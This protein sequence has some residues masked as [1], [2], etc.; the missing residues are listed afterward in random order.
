[1]E[2]DRRKNLFVRLE[3]ASFTEDVRERTHDELLVPSNA[4]VK[5]QME[6]N[7]LSKFKKEGLRGAAQQSE[8]RAKE[9]S[10][11]LVTA[12]GGPSAKRDALMKKHA[13]SSAGSPF[14]S[15]TPEFTTGHGGQLSYMKENLKS[16]SPQVVNIY[17]TERAQ[18]NTFNK[19]EH[20]LLLPV[21][22]RRSERVGALHVLP[23]KKDGMVK[24]VRPMFVDLSG[25]KPKLY[26]G[27]R[28]VERFKDMSRK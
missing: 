21:G 28:A 6:S 11:K 2:D 5:R 18:P 17:E 24:M 22:A 3:K 25:E 1:M 10:D 12:E 15:G 27:A 23:V 19:R 13:T 8:R 20:E 14:I 16:G 26:V 9:Y 7:R 4:V